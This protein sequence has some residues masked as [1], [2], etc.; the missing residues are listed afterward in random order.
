MNTCIVIPAYNESRT[1]GQLL[2]ELSS[3]IDDVIV[4]DDGSNDRTGLIAKEKGAHVIFRGQKSGKGMSL[5][6]GFELAL[7]KDYDGVITLDGDGQHNVDDIVQFEREAKQHPVSVIVGNRMHAPEGMPF[8]RYCTN[9]FMSLIISAACHQKISD[10]QCGYRYISC[11]VLRKI[12][13]LC[14]SFEIETEILIKASKKGFKF[15]SVP[16][17]TIYRDEKSQINPFKDTIRFFSYFIKE[18]FFSKE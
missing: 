1:I 16:I 5:R 18:V 15:Y 10:T 2:D 6:K 12:D 13:L 4:V 9:R 11:D 8:I 17:Q 3:R 7:Q 14:C